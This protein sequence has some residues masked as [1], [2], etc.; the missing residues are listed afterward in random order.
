MSGTQLH[1]LRGFVQW[2][3][4]ADK[5]IKT[6]DGAE[7]WVNHIAELGFDR[8]YTWTTR[9]PRRGAELA[10]GSVFFVG[11]ERR[12]QTLFRMP[13]VDGY[14]ICMRPELIRVER[15]FVGQVRGW[16]YLEDAPPDLPKRDVDE[17]LPEDLA[18]ALDELGVG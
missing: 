10:G 16:R 8:F 3:D 15:L 4:R 12:A 6:V 11:G 7:D 17:D 13:F 9:R 2:K 18:Q 1:L 14:V 5:P